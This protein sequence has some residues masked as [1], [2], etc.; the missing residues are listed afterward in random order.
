M[1][2]RLLGAGGDDDEGCV[3]DIV[4]AAGADVYGRGEEETVVEVH[5]FALGAVG[6]Q[7][8]EDDLAGEAGLHEGVG[9]GGADIAGAD[10]A[11]FAR[12]G[13]LAP[14]PVSFLRLWQPP[15]GIGMPDLQNGPTERR[16]RRQ[17]YQGNETE[18]SCSGI[19]RAEAQGG[20]W[21][22]LPFSHNTCSGLLSEE[23][24]TGAGLAPGECFREAGVVL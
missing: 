10:D 21:S 16:L 15:A 22:R 9:E 20:Q 14:L 5:R 11:D 6:V 23:K 3:G 8:D 4:V 2:G 24:G 1:A 17:S 12:V 19:M 18:A 7:V 13:H